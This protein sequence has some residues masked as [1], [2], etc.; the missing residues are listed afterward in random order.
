VQFHVCAKRDG[1]TAAAHTAP[2]PKE[3]AMRATLMERTRSVLVVVDLQARLAPAIDGID[4]VKAAAARM[5]RAAAALDV[6]VAFTEQNPKGLGPTDPALLAAA[7]GAA[8]LGKTHFGA[9][10]EPAVAAHVEALR[11]A[12]RDQAVVLGTETHVCVLQTALQLLAV[13]W[14]VFVAEDGCGSRRPAD[15]SAGLTRLRDAGAIASTA[16]MAI[17]EWLGRADT[18][19]FRTLLP[20]IRDGAG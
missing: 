1:P 16:E 9:L 11:R 19:E 20:L 12:G 10:A 13:G 8:V 14:T 6:P 17:F 15:R 4:G 18:P 3:A 5:I 2:V 7:P